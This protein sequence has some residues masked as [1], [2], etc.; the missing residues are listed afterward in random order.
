[1]DVK[2][3][4]SPILNPHTDVT[5]VVAML[6]SLRLAHIHNTHAHAFSTS[7]TVCP[8]VTFLLI[9]EILKAKRTTSSKQLTSYIPLCKFL[10]KKIK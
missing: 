4:G 2:P 8:S 7:C 9:K 1:M 10:Y 6:F 3:E 5:P